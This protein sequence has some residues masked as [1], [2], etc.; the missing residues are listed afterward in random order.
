MNLDLLPANAE[1]VSEIC[2]RLATMVT[3]ILPESW[4]PKVS[5]TV[6]DNPLKNIL[7]GKYEFRI[8]LKAPSDG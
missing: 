7:S 3:G 1:S 8:T 5:F 4:S 2:D 6:A